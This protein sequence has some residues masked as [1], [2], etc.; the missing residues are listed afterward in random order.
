MAKKP[1]RKYPKQSTTLFNARLPF[2]L[3]DEI[4]TFVAEE[5][6][7]YGKRRYRSQSHFVEESIVKNLPRNRVSHRSTT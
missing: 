2:E 4:R 7:D 1:R 5:L 3:V 6:D